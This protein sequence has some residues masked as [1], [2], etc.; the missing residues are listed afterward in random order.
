M[1]KKQSRTTSSQ[2]ADP[3]DAARAIDERLAAMTDW[4]GSTLARVRQL[5][6]QALPDVVEDVKWRKP[7]NAMQGVPVWSNGGIICTGEV[8]KNAVKL[9]FP[10]GA[11]IDDPAGLFNAGLDGGT[12]R[13][14]DLHEGDTL[15]AA[16]FKALIR[17]AAKANAPV[18]SPT[19][20]KPRPAK[21]PSTAAKPKLLSG[22]NPQIAKADGD[23]PVQAYIAA[24]PGWK[25]EI[26]RRLD[27]LIQKS[28]PKVR[29][30]V[31]WNSPFYGLSDGW[32]VG[33]HCFKNYVRVTFFAGASLSPVP[34]GA[35]KIKNVR[36]LDIREG[37]WSA[38]GTLTDAQLSSWI[39]QAS[40]L[41]GW[42]GGPSD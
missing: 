10:K 6:K 39:T 15:S 40:T 4:R 12:R 29:K 32:F 8:Y 16:A 7:S 37:D 2:P 18:S 5:I 17:A 42:G 20:H 30:A 26:A 34:P 23:A 33:L 13:A 31:R 3:S 22:D 9:T 41:P 11:A 19:G 21:K 27:A 24:I 25:Q 28:V 36:Y 1:A 35:S 38:G 14:I